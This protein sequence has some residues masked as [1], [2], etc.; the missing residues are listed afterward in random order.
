M[1]DRMLERISERMPDRMSERMPDRMP[2][3]V[4]ER[5]PNRISE[6]MSDKHVR[7]ECQVCY[8]ID[9]SIYLNSCHGGDHSKKSNSTIF[10]LLY[11][12]SDNHSNDLSVGSLES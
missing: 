2:E 8:N 11:L 7:Q 1:P 10:G 5:M 3:R 9:V 4:P 6:R 12:H